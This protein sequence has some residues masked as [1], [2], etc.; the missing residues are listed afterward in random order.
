MNVILGLS[1]LLAVALG[2]LLLRCIACSGL[3]STQATFLR[4]ASTLSVASLGN[5]RTQTLR[6]FS[7]DEMNKILENV[8]AGNFSGTK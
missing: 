3:I 6:A 4:V 1:P 5:I 2:A 8:P 7:A